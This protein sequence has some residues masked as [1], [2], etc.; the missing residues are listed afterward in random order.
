MLID[1]PLECL[2]IRPAGRHRN[3]N[4]VRTVSAQQCMEIEIAG[5]VHQYAITWLDQKAAQKVDRLRARL[6]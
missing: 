6:S 2:D 3:A 1:R 4:G 5:V